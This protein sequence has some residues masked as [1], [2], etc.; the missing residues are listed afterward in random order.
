M[1]N[2]E[3]LKRSEKEM[4]NSFFKYFKHTISMHENFI[5]LLKKHNNVDASKIFELI[6]KQEKKSNLLFS[7]LLDEFM[8]ILQ[9]ESPIAKDLRKI[10]SLISSLYDLERMCDY[11]DR[12]AKFINKY[13]QSLVDEQIDSF[14]IMEN[15][16]Y[17]TFNDVLVALETK[18]AKIIYPQIHN[19]IVNC[20]NISRKELDKFHN[21]NFSN[22]LYTSFEFVSVWKTFDRTLDHLENI[23]ENFIYMS[24][25]KFWFEKEK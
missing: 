24:N 15:I 14:L 4:F 13:Q 2:Y 8:W 23:V 3:S 16:I 6:K 20:S 12:F 11:V 19:T 5:C 22:D 9:K 7:K 21:M 25:Y 17:Q 18:K 1:L 10:I